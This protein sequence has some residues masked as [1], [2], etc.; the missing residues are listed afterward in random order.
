MAHPP[1]QKQGPNG[2]A[3]A[4]AGI[5]PGRLGTWAAECGLGVAE[6]RQE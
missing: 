4:T 1:Q 2:R 3:L 5:K 6:E